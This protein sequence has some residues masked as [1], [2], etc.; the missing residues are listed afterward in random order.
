MVGFKRSLKCCIQSSI[1]IPAPERNCDFFSF[2]TTL[3][4]SL[5][6]ETLVDPE[7]ARKRK[8]QPEKWKRNTEKRKKYSAKGLPNYPTCNHRVGFQCTLLTMRDVKDFHAAFYSIPEKGKQDSFILKYCRA[9]QPN[10]R[11]KVKLPMDA[12]V[13]IRM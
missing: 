11:R 2:S 5:A 12:L 13:K 1:E 9:E 6:S 7:S 8:S 3:Q 10:P 4:S